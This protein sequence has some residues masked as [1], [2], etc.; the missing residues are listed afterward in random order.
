[1]SKLDD[2][3]HPDLVVL[4]LEAKDSTEAI[5]KL[6]S[7]LHFKGY[8][9]D[10]YVNAVLEREKKFPT[11]L[12]FEDGQIALPHTDAEHCI[13]PA[14]AVGILK[15]PVDFFEMAT[16]D[17]VVHTD[18]IFLL[19]IKVPEDQVEW[20]ARLVNLFQHPGFLN[21]L[22]GKSSAQECYELLYG[23]LRKEESQEEDKP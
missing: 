15:Q 6:A 20:L 21:N 17:S 16:L 14:I 8:V 4:G 1:M 11:G 18:L 7:L 19:S 3:L 13:N 5:Q 23:E 10:S 2:F 12:I 9:K 22:K